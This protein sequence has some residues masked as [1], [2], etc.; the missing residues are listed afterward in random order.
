[1]S[2][3]ATEFRQNVCHFPGLNAYVKINQD[4]FQCTFGHFAK[5]LEL[6]DSRQGERVS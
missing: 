1:M 5:K 3:Q 2:R 6:T 4:N